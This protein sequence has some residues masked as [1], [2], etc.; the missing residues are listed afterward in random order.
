[1]ADI[2][3]HSPSPSPS[4]HSNL[5]HTALED[6]F[7]PSEISQTFTDDGSS[8][9]HSFDDL[10]AR[11]QRSTLKFYSTLDEICEKYVGDGDEE[12]DDVMDL[13]NMQIVSLRGGLQ[14]RSDNAPHQFHRSR[15]HPTRFPSR[16]PPS[17]T[18]TNIAQDIKA[19]HSN[20]PSP[21]T[22]DSGDAS[23]WTDD[24]DD[25]I[26]ST[27]SVVP[28][29]PLPARPSKPAPIA[30]SCSPLP[31]LSTLDQS[32]SPPAQ[33]MFPLQ[34]PP[35]T[36][37]LFERLKKRVQERSFDLQRHHTRKKGLNEDHLA[38]QSSSRPKLGNVSILLS[39]SCVNTNYIRFDTWGST[40]GL[41]LWPIP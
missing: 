15:S 20:P 32:L 25:S 14:R 8:L 36:N 26:A 3:S 11:R 1:M 24:D 5:S 12:A 19:S 39:N 10:L 18:E 13:D 17:T 23:Q 40:N 2:T 28:L 21:G 30:S 35:T 38:S 22:Q 31:L 6:L 33:P 37:T 34:Y 27:S 29:E 4:L 16:P 9:E 41:A 7:A